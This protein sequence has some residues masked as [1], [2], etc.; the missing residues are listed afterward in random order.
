MV[1]E[2]DWREFERLVARIERDLAPRGAVVRSPDRVPDLVTGSL[3]EV[4]ASIRFTVGSAPIL[5]TIECRRRAAVQDDTW[6]EQLAAKKEKVGAAKT[7][8]VS[9]SGFSEPA[10][11]RIQAEQLCSEPNSRRMSQ[12]SQSSLACSQ[13]WVRSDHQRSQGRGSQSLERETGQSD[14][15]PHDFI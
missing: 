11:A 10:S 3:R 5:I 1:Q 2:E 4:D 14:P 13:R 9:A 15:T 12:A 8:A 6:I 7:I